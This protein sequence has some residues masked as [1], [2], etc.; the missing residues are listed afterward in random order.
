MATRDD[1]RGAGPPSPTPARRPRAPRHVPYEG[2]ELRSY[3]R[4]EGTVEQLVARGF[5]AEW[6]AR[7]RT[8]LHIE[9]DGRRVAV[10]PYATHRWHVRVYRTPDEVRGWQRRRQRE[11]DHQRVY[12]AWRDARR[13]RQ[14]IEAQLAALP[15]THDAFRALVER[16]TEMT[17]G[18][19]VG[20]VSG[21]TE[22]GFRFDPDALQAV[23]LHAA[24][25]RTAL[26]TGRTVFDAEVRAAEITR[27]RLQA[28]ELLAPLRDPA[29][30]A[31][32]RTL[33]AG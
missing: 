20:A 30:D 14:R 28:D 9:H 13:E 16:L 12:E 17:L 26:A 31:F 24:G 2:L 15:A 25:I 3:T 18:V 11:L 21:R 10:A 4:H 27:L 33:R 5:P 32:L 6:F 8:T 1:T 29:C 23:A 19:L 7:P 22:A